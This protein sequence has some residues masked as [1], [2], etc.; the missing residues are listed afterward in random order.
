M[1][2]DP[3]IYQKPEKRE[4]YDEVCCGA[5]KND[6]IATKDECDHTSPWED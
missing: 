3:T 4:P 1:K 2:I 6:L 5:H